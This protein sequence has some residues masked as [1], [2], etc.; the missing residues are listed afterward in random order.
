[1]EKVFGELFRWGNEEIS[2]KTQQANH[3]QHEEAN[4]HHES[5]TLKKVVSPHR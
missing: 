2:G 4:S 5:V 1:M 3:A